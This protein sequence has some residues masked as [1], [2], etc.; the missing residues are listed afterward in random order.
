MVDPLFSN[1]CHRNI[2]EAS[3]LS[4]RLE[5]EFPVYIREP[6]E[7]VGGAADRG[8]AAMGP[9]ACGS[10]IPPVGGWMIPLPETEM[11]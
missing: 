6:N 4:P 5:L 3:I 9:T 2:A 11:L 10:I 1:F 7:R 8:A